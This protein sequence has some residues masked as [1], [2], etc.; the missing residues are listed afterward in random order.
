MRLVTPAVNI[1]PYVTNTTKNRQIITKYKNYNRCCYVLRNGTRCKNP[2]V[3]LKSI[4]GK[5]I[6]SVYVM[7]CKTHAP[8]CHKK[9]TI[10]KS[11]CGKVVGNVNDLK[12]YKTKSGSGNVFKRIALVKNCASRR[13]EY[14]TKCMMGC[15]KDS[16]SAQG[17][18]LMDKRLSQHKFITDKLQEMENLLLYGNKRKSHSRSTKNNIAPYTVKKK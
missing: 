3:G 17:K 8:I 4:P 10:Y 18:K 11:I 12:R 15:I 5:T 1:R 13:L 16:G 7:Q 2:V 14:P 9:Y 6:R